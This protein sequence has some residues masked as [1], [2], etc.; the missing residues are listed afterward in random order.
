MWCML[1]AVV[2]GP[3]RPHQPRIGSRHN[4]LCMTGG[5]VLEPSTDT[6]L[7]AL[8]RAAGEP[9]PGAGMPLSLQL[10]LLVLLRCMLAAGV[11]LWLLLLLVLLSPAER[12]GPKAVLHKWLHECRL[13]GPVLQGCVLQQVVRARPR[14][15]CVLHLPGC[16]ANAL[17]LC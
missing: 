17:S 2:A 4:R 6:R 13:E 3:G 1:Q 16:A 8:R 10:L 12:G 11:L 14:L 5:P 9:T 7:A 15:P